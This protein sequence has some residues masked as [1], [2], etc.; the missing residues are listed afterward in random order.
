MLGRKDYDRSELEA[1]R[2]AISSQLAHYR[3]LESAI[4]DSGARAA[5]DAFSPG[6]LRGLLLQL[7]RYFVHRVRPVSGKDTNPLTELELLVDALLL[8]DGVLRTL[9]AIR[10]DPSKAVL[11]LRPGDTVAPS[12]EDL[13]R[14]SAAFFA[15]L[16]ERFVGPDAG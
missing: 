2:A 1:A 10:Y 9:G 6:F 14:F 12:P 4:G 3:A 11:G 7:D 13:E 16:E 5:F 8:N 15:V